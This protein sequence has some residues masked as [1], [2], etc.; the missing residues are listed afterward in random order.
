MNHLVYCSHGGEQST[1]YDAIQNA[2]ASIIIDVGFHV[3]HEQTH[4]LLSLSL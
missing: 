2:L 3:S 1:S 4:V